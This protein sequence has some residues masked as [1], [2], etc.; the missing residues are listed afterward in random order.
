MKNINFTKSFIIFF[1]IFF[2]G[3]FVFGLTK[4]AFAKKGT[5][6]LIAFAFTINMNSTKESQQQPFV[7]KLN[8][9]YTPNP[10]LLFLEGKKFTKK[11]ATKF[12]KR[13]IRFSKLYKAKVNGKFLFSEKKWLN[14]TAAKVL[15]EAA[16]N[17][18]NIIFYLDIKSCALVKSINQTKTLFRYDRKHPKD[19]I[20]YDYFYNL[21]G[22]I[23][24]IDVAKKT[25]I[26]QKS[27]KGLDFFSPKQS[28]KDNFPALLGLTAQDLGDRLYKVLSKH[29]SN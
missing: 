23:A 12:V 28:N 14:E 19:T 7:D 24:L 11:E 22:E 29:V 3:L 27:L 26:F 8:F 21:N 13:L 4:I 15:N 16:K 10:A 9:N 17:S 1:V 18:V 2:V 5:K 6:P 25:I 20:T